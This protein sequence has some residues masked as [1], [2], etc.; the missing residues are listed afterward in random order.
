[1]ISLIF[2][3][4]KRF[5]IVIMDHNQIGKITGHLRNFDHYMIDGGDFIIINIDPTLS[6][7]DHEYIKRECEKLTSSLYFYTGKRYLYLR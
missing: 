1:M 3:Y 6:K 2:I 5:S 4:I 7:E